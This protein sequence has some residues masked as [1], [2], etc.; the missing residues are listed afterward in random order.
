MAAR[1]GEYTG[2]IDQKRNYQYKILKNPSIALELTGWRSRLT[3]LQKGSPETLFIGMLRPYNESI[4]SLYCHWK[5]TGE[6]NKH[7]SYSQFLRSQY[8]RYIGIEDNF[9]ELKEMLDHFVLIDFHES[10]LNI[11]PEKIFSDLNI[12]FKIENTIKWSKHTAREQEEHRI[13]EDLTAAYNK[14]K[15]NKDIQQILYKNEQWY[16]PL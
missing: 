10:I 2:D 6:I 3:R 16:S 9:L 7:L 13:N 12:D 4:F 14:L 11:H 5:R 1:I 15:N 8:D